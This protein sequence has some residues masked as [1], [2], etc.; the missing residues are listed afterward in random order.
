MRG[1]RCNAMQG[2]WGTRCPNPVWELDSVEHGSGI[3]CPLHLQLGAAVP[4]RW[5]DHV[6]KDLGVDKVI[7]HGPY[8]HFPPR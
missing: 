5:E 4:S 8:Q 3:L 7:G 6:D 1:D 2:R